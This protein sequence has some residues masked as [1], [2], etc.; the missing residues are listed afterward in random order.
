MVSNRISVS[1]VGKIGQHLLDLVTKESRLYIIQ[2][3]TEISAQIQKSTE[4]SL[5][6][7]KIKASRTS[8]SVKKK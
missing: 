7:T 4:G 2:S 3:D 6:R 8:N 5:N 1:L